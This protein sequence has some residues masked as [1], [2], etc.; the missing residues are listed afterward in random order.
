VGLDCVGLILA[1]YER[2]GLSLAEIDVPYA[3]GD[4]RRRGN[5][6][7][8]MLDRRFK[9]VDAD[10]ADGFGPL[11]CQSGDVL[12]LRSGEL[13]HVALAIDGVA[14]EIAQKW[15]GRRNLRINAISLKLWPFVDGVYRHRKLL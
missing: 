5:I 7:L 6:L 14:L 15:P 12:V 8:Q 3:E 10:S 1:V 2:V 13:F 4:C 9:R 11:D